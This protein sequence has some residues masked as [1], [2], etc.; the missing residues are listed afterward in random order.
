MITCDLKGGLGNLLFQISAAYSLGLDNQDSVY[1]DMNSGVKSCT[2]HF[3]VVNV[4]KDNIFCR[5][6][7]SPLKDHKNH[8]QEPTLR[9]SPIPYTPDL[10][11]HGYFP[12]EKYFKHHRQEIL[13]LFAPNPKTISYIDTKYGELLKRETVGIHIRRGDYVR[14][15]ITLSKEYYTQALSNFTDG[16]TIIFFSDDIPWC[17]NAFDP[18]RKKGY[19]FINGE[20]DFIDLYVMSM[21]KNH[22]LS[23]STFSWWGSWLSTGAKKIYAPDIWC[24]KSQT[25]DEFDDIYCPSWIRV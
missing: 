7:D 10:Y 1:I 18:D 5:L 19:V 4:Y 3:T 16:E 11:I 13:N 12:C 6:T 22:I 24:E 23:N 14:L 8:Y 25:P 17:I 9:Y 21:C 20:K 15:G 2:P